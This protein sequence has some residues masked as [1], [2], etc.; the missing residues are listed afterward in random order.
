MIEHFSSIYVYAHKN[1]QAL[2]KDVVIIGSE[3]MI[4]MWTKPLLSYEVSDLSLTLEVLICTY[5]PM[6][7]YIIHL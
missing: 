7:A 5:I 2:F 3:P 1:I 6:Y 4:I